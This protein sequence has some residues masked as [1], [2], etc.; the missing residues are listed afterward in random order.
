[1][2]SVKIRFLAK[3]RYIEK[4]IFNKIACCHFAFEIVC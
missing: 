3:N 1:M 2:K 4:D